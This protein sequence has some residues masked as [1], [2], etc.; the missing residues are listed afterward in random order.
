MTKSI[1]DEII[2]AAATK[3]AKNLAQIKCPSCGKN[4]EVGKDESGDD[5]YAQCRNQK[6]DF[7]G[8]YAPT[9]KE[10]IKKLK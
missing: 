9:L 2:I 10:L 8:A 7:D 6:C 4:M 3:R 5:C 1:Q